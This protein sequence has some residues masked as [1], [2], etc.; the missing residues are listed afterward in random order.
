MKATGAQMLI[1]HN[2]KHC[3]HRIYASISCYSPQSQ[4]GHP[5]NNSLQKSLNLVSYSVCQVYVKLIVIRNPQI[6]VIQTTQGFMSPLPK[7]QNKTK[8][9][10]RWET[11]QGSDFCVTV[12]HL[13]R[14]TSETKEASGAPVMTSAFQMEGKRKRGEVGKGSP[15]LFLGDFL[16]VPHNPCIQT[17]VTGTQPNLK[18]VWASQIACLTVCQD[19]KGV[20]T[21]VDGVGAARN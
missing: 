6:T 15:P 11:S 21:K 12:A 20:L 18:E 2:L 16:E 7:N 4:P 10:H 14:A 19:A 3:N 9:F 17:S 8:T 13:Q 5:G 1:E